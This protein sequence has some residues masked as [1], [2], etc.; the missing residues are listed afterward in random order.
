LKQ[1]VAQLHSVMAV[2]AFP[3]ISFKLTAAKFNTTWSFASEYY[4][5]YSLLLNK[6]SAEGVLFLQDNIKKGGF[7]KPGPA[8]TRSCATCCRWPCF[9]R[10]VGLDDPQRSL[11]TLTILWFCTWPCDKRKIL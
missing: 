8:W 2:S 11:P 10:G 7:Q 4:L 3:I 6:K 9:G 1:N 5:Q